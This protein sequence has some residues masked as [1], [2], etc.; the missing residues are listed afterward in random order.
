MK[1]SGL[2][3]VFV[4][5]SSLFV[6]G[7]GECEWVFQKWEEDMMGEMTWHY[8]IENTDGGDCTADALKVWFCVCVCVCCF[9]C[10]FVLF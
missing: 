2:F 6:G 4:V 8:R 1:F 9:V 5:F 3:L 10:C 7:Y